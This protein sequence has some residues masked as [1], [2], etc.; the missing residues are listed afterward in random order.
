[1]C[2]NLKCY[3]M[4]YILHMNR[5]RLIALIILPTILFIICISVFASNFKNIGII[6]FSQEV[7]QTRELKEQ[8]VF[9]KSWGSEG[10]IVVVVGG[11]EENGVHDEGT[12]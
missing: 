5:K 12:K 7:N 3:L 6:A 4:E 1:M 8:Y 9:E 11:D 10:V 2:H